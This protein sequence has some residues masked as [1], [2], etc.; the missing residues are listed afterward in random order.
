MKV[1]D[2]VQKLALTVS[3]TDSV[4]SLARLMVHA[5]ASVLPVEMPGTGTIVGMVTA[6][7]ILQR[8]A[9]GG[10]SSTVQAF[11]FMRPPVTCGAGEDQREALEKLAASDAHV[12]VVLDDDRSFCGVVGD[13][14]PQRADL[15]FGTLATGQDQSWS[16]AVILERPDR[17]LRV[18]STRDAIL[19]LRHHWPDEAE[20]EKSH[21]LSVCERA[22]DGGVEKEDVRELFLR[23]AGAANFKIKSWIEGQAGHDT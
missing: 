3:P 14:W 9:D 20:A 16:E 21:V 7:D 13:G 11:E 4:Q 18:Q 5:N 12:L 6:R 10:R 22:L 23:A 19:V 15:P 8:V 2:V 1:R 17:V